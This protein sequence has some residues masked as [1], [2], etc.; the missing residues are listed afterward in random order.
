M[1]NRPKDSSRHPRPTPPSGIDENRAGVRDIDC[2]EDTEEPLVIRRADAA[3]DPPA[4]PPDT[5]LGEQPQAV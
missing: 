1:R 4:S 3:Q 5:G 2:G